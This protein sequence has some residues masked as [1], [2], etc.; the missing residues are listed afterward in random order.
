VRTIVLS[1]D[2]AFGL[3]V[4]CGKNVTLRG[5]LRLSPG[6][7]E[8]QKVLCF[9]WCCAGAPSHLTS[10]CVQMLETRRTTDFTYSHRA[11]INDRGR[12]ALGYEG[13]LAV[14]R[15]LGAGLVF[16]TTNEAQFWFQSRHS[17]LSIMGNNITAPHQ[18]YL[19]LPYIATLVTLAFFAGRY[20]GPRAP[21][22][23][24]VHSL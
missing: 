4:R 17:G 10:L 6:N 18:R 3:L 22:Q 19:A 15:A 21:R 2:K 5:R 20:R 16:G 7:W 24:Y 14:K 23:P 11:P 8:R 12:N 9:L 1:F 13:L